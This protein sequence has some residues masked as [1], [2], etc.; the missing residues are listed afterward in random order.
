IAAGDTAEPQTATLTTKLDLLF[1]RFWATIEARQQ[2]ELTTSSQTSDTSPQTTHPLQ[3]TSSLRPPGSPTSRKAPLSPQQRP[4]EHSPDQL[5]SPDAEP[6]TEQGLL[7]AQRSG[8]LSL[9]TPQNG[10]SS[11]STDPGTSAEGS[12]YVL[13]SDISLPPRCLST[14]P[15]R[16][17]GEK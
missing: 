9:L 17:S 11:T 16:G 2:S 12:L 15:H 7:K 3:S 5:S 14:H 8:T 4:K 6:T 1:Q 13:S 10:G